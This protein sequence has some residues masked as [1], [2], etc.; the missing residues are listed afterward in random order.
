M[1]GCNIR[2][3]T[4][5]TIGGACS[6]AGLLRKA[7]VPTTSIRLHVPQPPLQPPLVYQE[8]LGS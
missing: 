4:A 5:P 6:Q 8:M 2:V 1:V 3:D 7:L